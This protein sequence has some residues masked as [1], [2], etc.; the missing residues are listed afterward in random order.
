MSNIAN[1][2]GRQL[3]RADPSTIQDKFLVG[4]QG[5]FTCAGDGRPIGPG[6]HGWLHW[7]DYPIPDGGRPNLDLWPDVSEYSPSELFP[8]PGLRLASGEQAYLFSSRHPKTVKRH[9]HWMALHGV[10]GAFL[11]RFVGQCDLERGN[12]G[13][14]NLRDEVGDRVREAAEQEGRVFAIMYDVAGVDPDRVQR[15]IEQDWLHL[16]HERDILDSPSYLREKG[17]PV[18]AIW[19]LGFSHAKHDPAVARAITSFIRDNTPGGAYIVAGTP[20]HWRTSEHDADPNPE[21]VNV[22]LEEFDAISPWTVGRYN[23]LED[24]DRFAEEKI[25]G[26]V[27]LIRRKNEDFENGRGGKRR[28]DYIPV[29]LPGGSGYNLSQGN[30]SWNGIPRHGGRF[31]WRQIVNVKR[32]GVRTIYGAMWDEYDEGT[33]FLPAVA[34][35]RQLPVHEKYKFMALDEDG[36]DLP[37]DWYMRICGFAVEGLRGER[38]ILETFPH[39]ELQDYWSSRPHYEDQET[40]PCASG[41]GQQKEKESTWE[42]WNQQD[43]VGGPAEEVPPPPYT[44]EATPL[45]APL[46]SMDSVATPTLQL[47]GSTSPPSP[48]VAGP[49]ATPPLPLAT[50]PSFSGG[51]VTEQYNRPQGV[52][53]PVVLSSRP[54]LV[55]SH[56]ESSLSRPSPQHSISD[57]TEEFG[58]QSLSSS[59]RPDPPPL[60]PLH[61]NASKRPASSQGNLHNSPYSSPLFPSSP[62]DPAAHFPPSGNPSLF[63]E[64]GGFAVQPHINPAPQPPSHAVWPP[65][66]WNVHTSP[67]PSHGPSPYVQQDTR[68]Q[69]SGY[70]PGYMPAYQSPPI[71]PAHSRPTPPPG[72]AMFP[73]SSSSSYPPPSPNHAAGGFQ[74]PAAQPP[75]G[76]PGPNAPHMG[77]PY[78]SYGPGPSA[79]SS[80]YPYFSTAPPGPQPYGPSGSTYQQQHSGYAGS[81]ANKPGYLGTALNM[82]GGAQGAKLQQLAQSTGGKLFNKLKR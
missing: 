69:G 33:N 66:E 62:N 15:I 12:E 3:R 52:P 65:P 26:D 60:H 9:F 41:S 36:Y 51:S 68:P 22:W 7:F 77:G 37:P 56:T 27:E 31:L 21:F 18:V 17:K 14:R 30:W 67:S 8:A 42:E 2:D 38:L 81:A 4:Y 44:L 59:P 20:A 43:K 32:H 25:K 55:P 34:N 73:P 29:V 28:V 24:A 48:S 5:W 71:A 72:G 19:G 35:K 80:A 57:L 78:E 16:I 39:K 10:D 63:P 50:R 11:Q 58:R 75:S 47:I 64:P 45:S 49:S 54:S 23:T 53:P 76:Y 40:T 74:F 46:S 13:V 82:I 6:H 1:K 79:G 61:P 70:Q